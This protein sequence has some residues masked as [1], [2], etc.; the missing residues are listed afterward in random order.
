MKRTP[1]R[2]LLAGAA[3]AAI[4]LSG[5]AS[6][7]D[8]TADAPEGDGELLASVE[9][10]YGTIDIP[11]P[12]DGELTVVA[13]GWSDAEAAL[14]LG[15][16]PVAVYDWISFG[17]EYKGV[18]PWATELFGDDVPVVIPRTDDALD[19]ELIQSLDPDLILNVN[20]AYDEAQFERLS[21]IAPTVFGPVGAQPYAPGW[22]NQT[23]LIADALGKSAEGTALIEGVDETIADAAAANPEF[24]GK[25]AASG[26]KFGEAYGVNLPGDFRWDLLADLGFELNPP[27]LD[28][29]PLGFYADVTVEQV[30]VFDADVLVMMP[31]GYTIEE[32][33]ADPLIA[34][35]PVVED[36]RAVFLDPEDDITN[37]FS[38][39]SVL[40][41]P[42]AVDE[43]VPLLAEAASQ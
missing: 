38:V 36:G 19:Y 34:S 40:S 10:M 31:I 39:A 21:E 9:T 24:A 26:S 27:I 35:L 11:E 43:L 1:A 8:D 29:P 22:Q 30:S 6:S 14:A 18:G 7:P 12:E 17:D 28:L 13:L 3:A 4:T 42:A 2:L 20:S 5:C 37:A 33:E 16:K 23:Q 25:T 32:L 41:I 15:V